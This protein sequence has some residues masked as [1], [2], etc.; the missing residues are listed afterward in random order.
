MC[1]S[2]LPVSGQQ[3]ASAEFQKEW[4]WETG[5]K[6]EHAALSDA[7]RIDVSNALDRWITHWSMMADKTRTSILQQMLTGLDVPNRGI[8][9][10]YTSSEHPNF[11]LSEAINEC[12]FISLD[13]PPAI[14][15][16]VG[17]A[18]QALKRM[19]LQYALLARRNPRPCVN[20]L[21]EYHIHALPELDPKFFSLSRQ[22]LCANVLA[23]QNPHLLEDSLGGNAQGKTKAEAIMSLAGT[24]IG[25]NCS[26]SAADWL[27]SRSNRGLRAFYSAN[28]QMR[29]DQPVDLWNPRSSNST[30]SASEHMDFEIAPREWSTL[31]R[32]GPHMQAE[33]IIQMNREI[34]GTGTNYIRV[35]L[36]QVA[37]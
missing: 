20:L 17:L 26:G 13:S 35:L 27:A 2:D 31:L 32:A 11:V 23:L 28:S 1:S 37:L 10:E 33:A 30:T 14:H 24:V 34:R 25:F 16:E 5:E 21:D 36:P 7:K 6:A 18:D 8:L 29:W 3:L 12:C 15:R 9:R 4:W 19:V 22:N